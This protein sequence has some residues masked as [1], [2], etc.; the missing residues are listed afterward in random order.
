[1]NVYVGSGSA[2]ARREGVYVPGS[3]VTSETV[4]GIIALI[5]RDA[6]RGWGYNDRG[7]KVRLS[8]RAAAS[9]LR[10]LVAL[11]AK[12]GGPVAK[13]REAVRYALREGAVPPWLKVRLAGRGAARVG[14]ELVR[15]GITS[16][17]RTAVAV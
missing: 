13:V 12:H 14:E 10:Y 5:L 17:R 6:R 2:Y 16:R 15:R 1:M 4:G 3:G 11:A 7:L 9:R 8:R